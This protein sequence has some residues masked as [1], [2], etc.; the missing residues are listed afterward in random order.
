M[1]NSNTEQD[2]EGP[3]PQRM[4]IDN[5]DESEKSSAEDDQSEE[6]IKLAKTNILLRV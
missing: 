5:S 2:V 6:G 1:L 4:M 3:E